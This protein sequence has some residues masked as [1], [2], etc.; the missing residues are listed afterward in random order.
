MSDPV[1]LPDVLRAAGLQCDIF[2]G[3]FDRGHGDF[4]NI[5]GVVCHHTGSFGETPNG[6]ANHPSLGLASQLFLDRNG[7]YTLCGVGVAWHA[8]SGSWPGIPTNAANQY[9]IGIEAQNDGGG[10]PGKPHHT[11]WSDAQYNAYV[12]GVAAILNKLQQ[13]ESHAIGHKDWAGPAQG[14]WDPGG[15]DMNIFRGDVGGVLRAGMA[16]PPPPVNLIDQ[17]Y[18]VAQWLGK[19]LSGEQATADGVGRFSQF[20]N[21]YIYWH[22]DTGAF[23]IP[24]HLF[25][26]YAQYGWEAGALGYP[27]ARHTVLAEGDVQAFQRGVLFRKYG[28]D[29][30]FVTGAIGNR[31]RL[32]DW[33]HGFLGWP[34]TNEIPKGGMIW[35]G[36]EHGRIAFAPDGT[37]VLAENG[38][39]V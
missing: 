8:G 19:R 1:W 2:P 5:W 29:G 25:E 3:A 23:A 4:G 24:M 16:P 22:P 36:F 21:G 18:G 20:E 6:I 38:E 37:V 14:K 10:S 17:E 7:K 34:L 31:Y 15:I 11:P 32:N 28:A 30:F 35:Q 13:P 27:V 26:S 9:T 12:R 39:F 33:E